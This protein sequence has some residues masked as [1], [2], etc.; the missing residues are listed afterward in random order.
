V[1]YSNTT[2]A[3]LGE[4][5]RLLR[6]AGTITAVCHENAD[7]DS[8]G[9]ALAIKLIGD[10]LGK[11]VEV[12]S[13]DG[14]PSALD[15]LP[16]AAHVSRRSTLQPDLV[17]VCD[18]A[19]LE[20]VGAIVL[21]TADWDGRPLLNIDHHATNRRF[22]TANYVDPSAAA[23][24]QLVA[25][26]LP[27]L[28]IQPDRDLATLLLV[29]ILRDSQG[30]ADLRTSSRTF[31]AA[32][33]LIDAGADLPALHRQIL[34]K[35][36]YPMLALWGRILGSVGQRRDGRIVYATLPESMLVETGTEHADADGLAEFIARA[37]G[38]DVTLLL[39]EI[40]PARTRVSLRTTDRIDATTLAGPFGGGGHAHRAGCT[41]EAPLDEAVGL[42]LPPCEAAL[43]G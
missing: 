22:G 40:E 14:V 30:F 12:V 32:A 8:L 10:R 37:T 9:A 19:T 25:E 23:T 24:C 34:S 15:F 31:R 28:D 4:I 17:V 16:G 35:M 21:E 18:A 3:D 13:V 20:R 5:A 2:G 6:D 39:R 33:V 41:I 1:N 26:L 7:A 42:V 43:D 38:A 29:G 36:S 27:Y 11:T